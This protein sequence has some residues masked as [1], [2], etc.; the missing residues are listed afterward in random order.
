MPEIE[1]RCEA[2]KKWRG[3]VRR[4]KALALLVKLKIQ[5][6]RFWV[7]M[8]R[9]AIISANNDLCDVWQWRF[10]IECMTEK[11]E[12]CCS[13]VMILLAAPLFRPFDVIHLLFYVV[14]AHTTVVLICGCVRRG[15]CFLCIQ[16]LGNFISK[17]SVLH[18]VATAFNGKMGSSQVTTAENPVDRNARF[19]R[20]WE[21]QND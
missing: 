7:P 1:W 5:L 10:S 17:H 8:E 2:S 21:K 15:M 3:K 16:N 4:Q 18:T 6:L 13:G 19:T 12:Q 9:S 14:H 11:V 20:R